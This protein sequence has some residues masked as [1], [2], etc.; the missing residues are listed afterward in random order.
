MSM[1]NYSDTELEH[2]LEDL[3]S[4]LVERKSGWA[5]DAP[6]K[7]RQAVCAFANDLPDHRK[8]GVF[9]V[10]VNDN[11]S[12]SGIPVT[13]QL[14][15]T[16]ADIKTDGK[17]PHP[18][19][20]IVQKRT[21]KGTEIAVVLVQ[22]SSAPPIRYNGRVWIRIGPRRGIATAQD[23]RILNERRRFG[24]LPFDLQPLPSSSL[25]D[26]SRTIF[27][28]EYFPNAIAPDILEAN[29]RTYEQRLATCKMI[30]AP[31]EPVPT[32]LGMLVLGKSPRDWVPS[33]YV[34][35]LRI[36]GT[37]LSDDII[38][39]AVVDGPMAQIVRRLDE[40]MD[41]HNRQAVDL[42]SG[43][44]ERRISPYPRTALEQ[45]TRNALMH[46]SFEG[47]QAPVRVTWFND[48]IEIFSPG[49]PYGVVTTHNFGRPGIVDYRNP[50]LAEAMKV[51]G[52]VQRFG[53]GIKT[54]QSELSKNGNPPAEFTAEAEHVLVIVRRRP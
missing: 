47:T 13:D 12:P 49:G 52:Y 18:L 34:Q 37:E 9:A 30:V 44:V 25:G 20:V 45:L 23:E 7:G 35:F 15:R 36:D 16:L 28:E 40:K 24:D 46:R 42:V 29:D 10:G 27:D 14:L 54:A 6:E 50:H 48:R 4:D 38:D 1:V 2:L 39:E 51:L 33:S 31:D 11:G 43:S 41:S 22:P 19:S 26:L 21:Y 8:P 5:G 53:V 17:I 3:E 32:L